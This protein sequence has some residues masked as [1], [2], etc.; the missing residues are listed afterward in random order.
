MLK[1]LPD[2]FCDNINASIF[3]FNSIESSLF[4]LKND[5]ENLNAHLWCLVNSLYYCF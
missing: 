2:D 4:Y 3:T 1:Y 5:I